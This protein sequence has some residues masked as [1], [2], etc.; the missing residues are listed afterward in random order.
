[1][2]PLISDSM[3]LEYTC[4]TCAVAHGQTNVATAVGGS[5]ESL[6]GAR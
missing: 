2:T 3:V 4:G 5:R 6:T 1:M